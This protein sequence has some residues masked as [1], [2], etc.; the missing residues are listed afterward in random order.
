MKHTAFLFTPKPSF[1]SLIVKK[2]KI[3]RVHSSRTPKRIDRV[4]LPGFIS[5]HVHTVQ[6]HARNFAENLELLDW[7]SKVIWPFEAQLNSKT[8]YASSFTGMKECLSNGITTILDMG[9]SRHT[10]SVFK[11]AQDSGIRGFIGKALMD[12]GPK[13]LID[14]NPLEEVFDHLEYWHGAERGR[15]SVSLCPRFVLSCSDA[16]LKKVGEISSK[17][18]LIHHTHAS[19]N[20]KECLWIEK[21]HR[22]SNIE[23]LEKTGS[24]NPHTVI[25]HGVHLSDNDI[26]ILRKRKVSI[27]HCPTS[28]LK[29]ASGIAD[30]KRLKGVNLS[31]GVDGAPCN[32]ILDPFFEMRLA[33][34]LSR[35]IHG[36]HG[37]SAKEI[38]WMAT[39]GGARALHQ[40]K[41]IGSLEAG[42][43]ADFLVLKVPESVSFNPDFPYES[44]IH[45]LSARHIEKVFVAGALIKT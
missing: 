1:G 14:K 28:N 2:G 40:E 41:K 7:L 29:L 24:L 31:L 13:S 44:L 43:E 26:R 11:A 3:D 35:G 21:K 25:A 8:T 30:L 18:K 20:K 22:V 16:L 45:S 38:F 15:I 5:T 9:T 36:L 19:E 37:K 42:K 27:S 12:Q 6:T 32:N 10:Q 4:I 33:H 34:L 39:Q 17:L 23:Y